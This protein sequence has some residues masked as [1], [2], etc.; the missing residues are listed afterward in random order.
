LFGKDADESP[1]FGL[2]IVGTS[3]PTGVVTRGIDSWDAISAVYLVGDQSS[4]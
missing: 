2:V 1:V 4:S 3:Y